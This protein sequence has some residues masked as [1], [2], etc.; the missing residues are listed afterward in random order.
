MFLQFHYQGLQWFTKHSEPVLFGCFL[1]HI[2]ARFCNA[3]TSTDPI[4]QLLLIIF[5]VRKPPLYMDP[6]T[7]SFI[8]FA[9]ESPP[10]QRILQFLFIHF[11][12]RDQPYSQIL[13]FYCLC[14]PPSKQWILKVLYINF[15]FWNHHHFQGP[16]TS[17]L[18]FYWI[19]EPPTCIY[20]RPY[21]VWLLLSCIRETSSYLWSLSWF[22]SHN[23]CF[24]IVCWHFA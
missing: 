6:A 16:V 11:P 17:V 1:L 20:V 21:N 14:K 12:L 7:W 24:N 13:Q 23:V 22:L 9:E 5:H 4:T 10:Y 8:F 19:L 2:I 3:H 18:D 15:V